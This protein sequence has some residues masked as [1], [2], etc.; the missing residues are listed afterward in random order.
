[1]ETGMCIAHRKITVSTGGI[2]T[3]IRKRSDIFSRIGIAISLNAPNDSIRASLMPVNNRHSISEL[4][5]AAKYFTQKTRRRMTFEY[6]LIKGV[7]DRDEHARALAS[8]CRRVPSKINLILF[9]EFEGSPF[10]RPD[11]ATVERFQQILY[12]RNLTAIIRKSKGQDILASCGQ[13]ATQ[14][15]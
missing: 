11:D 15:D 8:L 9:N 3:G 5:D 1:M 7:N 10:K 14:N 4:M 6:I 12:K 2:T 13:L